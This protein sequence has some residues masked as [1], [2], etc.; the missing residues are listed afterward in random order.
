MRFKICLHGYTFANLCSFAFMV[1]ENSSGATT[2]FY[3]NFDLKT[4][5]VTKIFFTNVPVKVGTN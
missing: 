1:S 3:P 5:S 2:L 4:F